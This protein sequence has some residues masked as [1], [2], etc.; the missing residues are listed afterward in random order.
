MAGRFT[1]RCTVA[2]VAAA[3]AVPYF[4]PAVLAAT[5]PDTAQSTPV[6]NAQLDEMLAAHQWGPLGAALRPDP[7][8][9]S[10]MMDWLHQRIDAGGGI[11]LPIIFARDLWMVGE[12]LHTADPMSDMRVTAA[13]M[14]LYTYAL[15]LVDGKTCEDAT[16]PAH[17]RDQLFQARASTLGF[18]R[19]LPM[20]TKMKVVDIAVALE[21]KTA[22]LRGDDDLVC[23]D[24][25]A[26]MKA[27]I[28]HGKQSEPAPVPGMVGRTV[29]VEPPAGWKPVEI[30]A[31]ISLPLQDEIRK[32]LRAELTKLVTAEPTAL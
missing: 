1:T 23:R 2:L 29:L 9:I 19:T 25:L 14:T 18:L 12:Q 21:H 15:I 4:T 3:L 30:P 20:N 17:R 10:R 26:Q 27:G 16:A 24:G 28:E 8:S 32:N 13:M 31:S 6:S 22:P 7:Q 11:L 5:Q